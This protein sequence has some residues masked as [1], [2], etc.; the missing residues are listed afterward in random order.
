VAAGG[1]ETRDMHEAH[2]GHCTG[3][4]GRNTNDIFVNGHDTICKDCTTCQGHGVEYV[5]T[6]CTANEDSTCDAC[7]VC[8]DGQFILSDCE[9]STEIFRRETANLVCQDCMELEV[10]R[11]SYVTTLCIKDLNSDF[12]LAPCTKCQPGEWLVTE[13]EIGSVGALGVDTDCDKCAH[14]GGC[15]PGFTRCTNGEDE[16]CHGCSE[17]ED[18]AAQF[19]TWGHCCEHGFMG[20]KCGWKI[21]EQGCEASGNSFKERTARRGGWISSNAEKTNANFVNWCQTMCDAEDEC[22]AYEVEDCLFGDEYCVHDDSL[23]KLKNHKDVVFG[24]GEAGQTCIVKPFL[25]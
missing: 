8:E 20:D 10:P 19:E 7:D 24:D 3:L 6:E 9:D 15:K 21:L 14:I 5:S 1:T 18:T 12:Q 13:C 2:N 22:T 25:L 23:C 16:V 11:E 17:F 4:A